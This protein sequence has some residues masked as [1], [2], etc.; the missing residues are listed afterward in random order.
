MFE[1]SASAAKKKST[2][3]ALKKNASKKKRRNRLGRNQLGQAIG[4]TG[5]RTRMRLYEATARLLGLF[6]LRELTVAAIARAARTSPATFYVY[7]EDVDDAVLAVISEHSQSTP[8]LLTM[9]GQSWEARPLE[10]ARKFVRLYTEFWQEHRALFHARNL[11]AEEGDERFR[12]A[13]ARSMTPLLDV[14]TK[15]IEGTLEAKRLPGGLHAASMA[16]A[17]LAMLE[18][19]AEIARTTV[20]AERGIDT[21]RLLDSAAFMVATTLEGISAFEDSGPPRP[22]KP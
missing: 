2:V 13:R 16:G 11:A 20:N 6:P 5:M 22:R 19:L 14:L 4:A 1:T 3:G 15:R 18:R 10:Q 7:F 12:Q 9:L 21:A 17:L 8:E